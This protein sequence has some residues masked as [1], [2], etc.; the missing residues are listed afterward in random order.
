MQPRLQAATLLYAVEA[1]MTYGRTQLCDQEVLL[2][3][4][5][6]TLAGRDVLKGL[7]MDIE[8]QLAQLAGP[9]LLEDETDEFPW[10]ASLR[11]D[12]QKHELIVC[13]GGMFKHTEL[14]WTMV[15]MEAFPIVKACHDL[16]CF[17]LHPNGFRLYCDHANLAYIFAPSVE[18]KKHLS[19]LRPLGDV[20][21]VSATPD[22]IQAAQQATSRER[23]RLQIVS[24]EV[25]GVV[26]ITNRTWIPSNAKDLIAW[27]LMVAHGGSQGHR[28]QEPILLALKERFY[29]TKLEDK[30]AKFVRQCLLCQY[31]KGPRQIPHL[32]GPLLQANER[33]EVVQWDFLSLGE[34]FGDS[35][36]LLMEKDGLS[37]FCELFRVPR[38]RPTS[39]QRHLPFGM[40]DM[41]LRSDQG[42][43]FRNEM[44]K[45]L[46]ARLKMEL[47]FSPVYS[48]WLN[49]TVARLNKDANLNHTRVQSLAGR[50][51]VKVFTALPASSALEV[52][53]VPAT[54]EQGER[55]VELGD[56]GE[57][58]NRLRMSLHE[59]Y[60]EVV[61]V[62][63]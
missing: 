17:L 56:I 16:D 44:M 18:L 9:S 14:N 50:A 7:G 34:G 1:V 58:V 11:V 40:P 4:E 29:I 39:Q 10:D 26:L 47:S 30:V 31:F 51:T 62:K 24:V 45:H 12:E 37:H 8:Q 59:I 43:H 60:Q 19:R 15:E 20:E 33:N 25:D 42:T 53:V 6:T 41:G 27:I 23:S 57:N 54:S 3:L 36:Y 49:R 46:A 38:Q 28:G 48:P 61:D 22:D 2:D 52:M 35:S 5:L 63:E 13:K 32:Y 21:F 55:V